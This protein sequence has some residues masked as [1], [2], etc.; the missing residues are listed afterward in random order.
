MQPQRKFKISCYEKQRHYI[1]ALYH[2]VR[3]FAIPTASFSLGCL[4][5]KKNKL[6]PLVYQPVIARR[7][8]Q[9]TRHG[10][11]LIYFVFMRLFGNNKD[12]R[13]S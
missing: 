4:A 8:F 3:R 6:R 13:I 12:R 11:D 10:N 2:A 9:H 1:L 5:T 7:F